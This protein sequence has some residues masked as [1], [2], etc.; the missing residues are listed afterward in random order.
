MSCSPTISKNWIKT[1]YW[2]EEKTDYEMAAARKVS[3]YYIQDLIKKYD[4][5]KRKNG[6]K[7]KGK[8]GYVMPE[9]EKAKHRVQ[10][11]AKEIVAF[12]GKSNQPIGTFRSINHAANELNLQR[13]H[14]R[15]CLNPKKSRWSSKG[16][17][18]EY[19]R[20]K[21]EIIVERRNNLDFSL[22][23]EKVCVGL[24]AGLPN[25]PIEE[26]IAHFNNKL[27]KVWVELGYIRG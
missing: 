5:G 19:K 17:R 2:N 20:Y 4:L 27:Q 15:D 23:F 22:E 25:Y 11:H 6:I 14:I 24:N 10:P 1:K 8:K 18:F 12:K 9:H 21:G 3:V 26:R 7:L 13:T 16:Y